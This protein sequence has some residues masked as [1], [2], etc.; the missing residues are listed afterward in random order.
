M[1]TVKKEEVLGIVKSTPNYIRPTDRPLRFSAGDRVVA[2]NLSPIGHTR[3]PRYA[4][5]R[6]GTIQKCYGSFVFPDTVAHGLGE[7]PQHLFSVR[8]DAA[9]LWGQSASPKHSVYLDL[10]DDYIA[11]AA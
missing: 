8:F 7:T 11:G 2:A 6:V 1:K 5:G 9:E 4:R 10:W 3:L